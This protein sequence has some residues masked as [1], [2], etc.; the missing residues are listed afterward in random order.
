MSKFSVTLMAATLSELYASAAEF[1]AM[2]GTD[3][4]V[5]VLSGLTPTP[6]EDD[7]NAAPA[8][9]APAFDTT[10]LP[11]DERIHSGNKATNSDGTWKR[12][13]NTPDDVFASVQ[14]ELRARNSAASAAPVASP[15]PM[16]PPAVQAG[17]NAAMGIPGAPA[18]MTVAPA[19]APPGMGFTAPAPAPDGMAFGEFMTKLSAAL[20][21]GKFTQPEL[22]QW[23]AMPEWSIADIGHLSGDPAKTKRFH[24]W[25]AQYGKI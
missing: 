10:G 5:Q 23:R 11:W 9:N 6:A 16:A 22:D 4:P 14:A 24:D 8:V 13:R 15:P 17:V 18:P 21:E 2:G 12:R 3:G 1:A 7:D 25:L 19:I 20:R